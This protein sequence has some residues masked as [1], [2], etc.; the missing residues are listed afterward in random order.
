MQS[1]GKG[2][3]G[4]AWLARGLARPLLR[5]HPLIGIAKS[6]WKGN[7]QALVA[8]AFESIDPFATWALPATAAWVFFE[9]CL[10]L[11]RFV[12]PGGFRRLAALGQP[13]KRA[14][15]AQVSLPRNR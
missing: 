14:S 7:A 11:R 12:Q 4:A 9:A 3:A 1:A 2:R 10:M 8:R 6:I 15:F 5:P 13:T